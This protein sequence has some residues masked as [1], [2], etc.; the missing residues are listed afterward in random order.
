MPEI[1]YHQTIHTTENKG[2]KMNNR[3]IYEEIVELQDR[4]DINYINKDITKYKDVRS[5]RPK[6][7][8]V[9]PE[10][11]SL[12]GET[13][14]SLCSPGESGIGRQAI[15]QNW[16]WLKLDLFDNHDRKQRFKISLTLQLLTEDIKQYR[17]A[18]NSP[19]RLF[20]RGIQGWQHNKHYKTVALAVDY[21]REMYD[22][23]K[24]DISVSKFYKSTKRDGLKRQTLHDL[25]VILFKHQGEYNV[26][27]VFK[28][29]KYE[30]VLDD[31]VSKFRSGRTFDVIASKY[32]KR[33]NLNDYITVADEGL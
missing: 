6:H 20:K 21:I 18:V 24:K 4:T 33:E 25:S 16:K 9:S 26:W 22:L 31:D 27:I 17:A 10:T 19:F 12:S 2:T 14:V 5:F 30:Y 7:L 28:N 3:K 8:V 32:I 23:Q 15:P 13:R 29:R 1:I 11:T